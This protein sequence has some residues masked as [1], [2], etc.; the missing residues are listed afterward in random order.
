MWPIGHIGFGDMGGRIGWNLPKEQVR[1]LIV[2]A[3]LSAVYG[4]IHAGAWR[5]LFPSQTEHLLWKI[6]CLVCIAGSLPA[7]IA[8]MAIAD[9]WSYTDI[10]TLTERLVKLWYE[11]L[12]NIYVLLFIIG[13]INLPVFIAARNYIVLEAFLSLRHIT[14]GAYAT[15][16]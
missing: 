3:S 5:F 13:A 11:W 4:G 15:V 1:L 14:I 12:S 2:V 9:V 6:S 7:T 10:Q 16:E 8:I